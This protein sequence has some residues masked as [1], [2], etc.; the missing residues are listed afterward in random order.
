MSRVKFIGDPKEDFAGP[1]KITNWDVPF[2]K[3]V[4]RDV[5]E[6]VAVQART[7]PHFVVEGEEAEGRSYSV[8]E[9]TDILKGRKIAIPKD[10][11]N[12]AEALMALVEAN[13]G[14]P[15]EDEGQ[16]KDE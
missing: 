12:D 16:D 10:A 11:K 6:H 9:L 3:N 5:P 14:L 7:H 4:F 15:P 1:D 2:V 13:G 8:A